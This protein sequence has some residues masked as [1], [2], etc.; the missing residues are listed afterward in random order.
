MLKGKYSHFKREEYEGEDWKK[1][2]L[3][4]N[5]RHYIHI[6]RQAYMLVKSEFQRTWAV[7]P[8]CLG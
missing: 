6:H 1:T 2:R 7:S 8:L 4:P 3:K 5:G